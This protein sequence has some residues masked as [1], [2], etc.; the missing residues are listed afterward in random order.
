MSTRHRVKHTRLGRNHG[1]NNSILR[2]LICSLIEHERIITTEAKAR[3]LRPAAERMIT[4]AKR[5]IAREDSGTM[6][7]KV[8]S[9][10]LLMSRL[11]HNRAVVERLFSDL[12]PRYETR[13]GGYTRMIKLGPRKIDS[14]RMA[15]VELVDIPTA[16]SSS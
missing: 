10:R 9:Y 5:G 15:V 7:A 13:N 1:Q 2:S 4:Q 12:A 6:G 3:V 8:H 14:A 16:G 11:A